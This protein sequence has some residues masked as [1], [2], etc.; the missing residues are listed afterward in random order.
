MFFSGKGRTHLDGHK[1][2]TNDHVPR[3]IYDFEYV[4]LP[5]LNMGSTSF[6]V[7][8]EPGDEVK[9]GQ[10]IAYRNDHFYMPI[11]ATV[12][13]VVEGI[14]KMMTVSLIYA[15][16]IKIKNDFK[17]ERVDA[18]L[19][20]DIETA[21][22]EE[23]VGG[24][25]EA[26]LAGRGGS[27]FPTYI[28]YSGNSQID[29]L[30]INGVECE[31]Y[32]TVDYQVML[33]YTERFILGTRFLM[34]ACGAPKAIIAIKKGKK[35]LVKKLEKALEG[36]DNIEIKEVPDV[37]PMGWERTLIQEIFNL[38]YD[39]LPSE[40]GIV[41]NNSTTAL[42]VA[43]AL[44]IGLRH[45]TQLTVSGNALNSPTNVVVPTGARVCDIVEKIGGYK[46][47]VSPTTTKLVMGGPMMGKAIVT[48]EVAITSYTNAALFLYDHELEERACLRCS[49]CVDYCPSGLQSVAIKDAE[50]AQDVEMLKKL[51]ADTC[52]ECGLCTYICPSRIQ[53]TDYTSKGKKRVLSAK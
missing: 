10:K 43:F 44:T 1:E 17:Y 28:K 14:E 40:I 33:Q 12:S 53:V 30:L 24:I 39:K 36:I 45:I 49:R 7:L 3:M 42:K 2:L 34:K 35:D 4:Y 31:P 22:K 32:I 26:G 38:D 27:G 52:V 37:Y 46:E 8:V 19:N 20:L 41:V 11:Y 5:L 50:R 6:E 13:G 48:D 47:D 21:T 16:H 18:A 15:Q 25:K 51:R 29:T 23:I 9:I